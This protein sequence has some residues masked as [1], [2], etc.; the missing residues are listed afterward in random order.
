MAVSRLL[1]SRAVVNEPCYICWHTY[2]EKVMSNSMF[3]RVLCP[4]H[5]HFNRLCYGVQACN[6]QNMKENKFYILSQSWPF[7]YKY[8]HYYKYCFPFFQNVT[9]I[10]TVHRPDYAAK[11]YKYCHYYKYCLVWFEILKHRLYHKYCFL[12]VIPPNVHK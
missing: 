8:C 11:N 1:L 2:Q 9:I 5:V 12:T 3:V 7:Y 10:S 4:F 6:V